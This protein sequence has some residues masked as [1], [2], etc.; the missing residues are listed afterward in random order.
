MEFIKV[1]DICDIKTGKYDANHSKEDGKYKFF[2]CALLPMKADTYSFDGKLVM[3]PGNG[4]NLGE[5]MYYE[6]KIE[7]YQRTY[8]LHNINIE[9]KF[10]YYFL[11]LNWKKYI[12]RRQ[13]GSATNYMKLEDILNFEVPNISLDMQ[14]K[15]IDILDGAQR[16]IDKRK[17]QIEEL[18]LL[19]K[20]KFIEMFGN[21]STNSKGWILDK[22]SNCLINIENGKSFICENYKRKGEYPAILKLSAVTYGV[23][24]QFENKALIDE[25]S[26]VEKVE[27]KKSDLLFT[28]KNTPELVGMS[29]YVYET[30]PSLMM[31][32][33]IFR[34]N[35]NENINKIFLWKLI[36]HDLFREKIKALSNGS[37]KSMS[38]ISKQRLMEL[39]IPVP[40]IELQ[41]QFAEFVK[42][43]DKLK[44]E[45]EKSLKELENNFNSLMNKAFK[46]ELF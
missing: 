41:N 5:V 29:A 31:P 40:P 15:I 4:A 12:L 45:M 8:V 2:T 26:F 46:G 43:V 44:F 25:F 38:N 27:V 39:K 7:A 32:D 30:E 28:R 3:L 18:D 10:L 33:L 21:P 13:I 6:G 1:K 19:V 37:A 36:N 23:Y 42:Q 22:L 14:K 20:S 16:L 9:A 24:N 11:K 17:K 34:L 35:T